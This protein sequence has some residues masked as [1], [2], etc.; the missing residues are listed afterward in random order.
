MLHNEALKNKDK[1]NSHYF[2]TSTR[3]LKKRHD[4]TFI[5]QENRNNKK[6]TNLRNQLLHKIMRYIFVKSFSAS[7]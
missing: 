4:H 5:I 7:K 3:Y 1:K 2:F 6:R